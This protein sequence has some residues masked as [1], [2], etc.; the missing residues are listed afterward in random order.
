MKTLGTDASLLSFLIISHLSSLFSPGFSQASHT[1]RSQAVMGY[2]LEEYT[3]C[4]CSLISDGH[5]RGRAKWFKGSQLVG[6]GGILVVSRDK[7]S[8]WC[9]DNVRNQL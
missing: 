6:S 9:D 3:T 5:P 7:S 1:C 4:T 8:E 2:F